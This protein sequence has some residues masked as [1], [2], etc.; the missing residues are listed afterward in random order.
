MTRDLPSSSKYDRQERLALWDQNIIEKSSI[1][2]AGV[3]GTGSELAKNLALLGIGTL[4]LVDDDTI[5][6]SN[7]NR[8]M[9]FREVD[10]GYKKARIAKKRIQ[11]Q[12]NPDI[13][14]KTYASKLQDIPQ[15]VFRE[16]D[17]IA[18]C[19]DNFLARQFINAM[20]IE[21]NIPLIDSATDGYFG[22]IQYIKSRLTACLACETPAPPDE[23]RVLT[24]PC[25]LVGVP[26]VREHCAWKALYD[27][28][29]KYE[30][31]P[32]ESSAEDIK[33]LTKLA[34]D[35]ARNNSFAEFKRKELLQLILF[36]VP[37]LITVNAVASGIQSQEIVKALFLE[38][39][40][41]LKETEQKTLNNLLKAQRFRIP[42]FS[43]YSALTGTINTFDLVPD[44]N[45]LVCS[46]SNLEKTVEQTIIVNPEASFE[47]ILSS[48]QQEHNKDFIGFRG[49]FLLPKDES[50]HKILSDGD[51]ITLSSVADNKE[52]R[53]EIK[54]EG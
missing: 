52:I 27:F 9:L 14:I 35:C 1:L 44:P 29:A 28:Y 16:V 39:K 18:G 32:V 34:N 11:E 51:R 45:C 12:F 21:L 6:F 50:I 24:A 8:Q 46:K 54:F 42:A 23:T 31:E 3:G 22:Q 20:A 49:N 48:L 13:G 36:H 5:E 47:S 33:E 26:R 41:F 7:L 10:V 40:D 38:K 30:R 53:L 25:T 15:K 19:V 2:I 4:I 43:I 17:I 37:S